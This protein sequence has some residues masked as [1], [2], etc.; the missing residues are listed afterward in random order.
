MSLI[1]YVCNDQIM[2]FLLFVLFHDDSYFHRR[3]CSFLFY[4]S[5]KTYIRTYMYVRNTLHLQLVAMEPSILPGAI[6]S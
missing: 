1:L 6:L 2:R 3:T 4:R 5:L